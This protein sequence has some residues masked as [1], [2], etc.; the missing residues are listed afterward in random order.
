[1]KNI[2]LTALS[3]I[4]ITVFGSCKNSSSE[5]TAK[6]PNKMEA[7]KSC[8]SG[9]NSTKE[10]IS[11][12]TSDTKVIYF[13]FSRR[14]IT[15]VQD[16]GDEKTNFLSLNLEKKGI[17]EIAKKYGVGG[18]ALIVVKNGKIVN[19]TNYAFMNAKTKPEKLKEKIINTIKTL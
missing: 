5:T 6:T 11:D 14:C 1:M 9:D 18:Q 2:L 10:S 16:L 7:K 17:A 3:I 13:H 15:C 19:L 4:C 8:C 12:N